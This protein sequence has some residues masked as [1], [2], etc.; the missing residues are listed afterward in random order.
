MPKLIFTEGDETTEH[1]LGEGPITIGRSSECDI[2][3]TDPSVSRLH[4]VVEASGDTIEVRDQ[5]SRSGI[6]V[7]GSEVS[8]GVLRDGDELRVGKVVFKA[9]IKGVVKAVV[10][11]KP[12]PSRR[13]SRRSA[14]G[15]DGALGGDEGAETR[16]TRRA[17]R[18]ILGGAKLSKR[19]QTLIKIVCAAIIVLTWV[20]FIYIQPRIRR[21]REGR[22]R[23]VERTTFVNP[24]EEPKRLLSEATDLHKRGRDAELEGKTV[25]AYTLTNE[26]KEKINRAQELTDALGQKYPGEAYRHIH[27]LASAVNQKAQA[28]R[29][30]EFKLGKQVERDRMKR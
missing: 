16:S 24:T 15:A 21:W 27:K 3:L 9:V 14:A 20:F 22:P 28:I 30:D 1:E 17:Q 11:E 25:E 5:E 8:D 26:A 29:L 12:A 7:N 10:K 4:V 13:S 2:K 6:R 19:Q 18:E 23:T